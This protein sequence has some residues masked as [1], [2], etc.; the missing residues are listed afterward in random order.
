M[1]KSPSGSEQLIPIMLNEEKFDTIGNSDSLLNRN[2]DNL[3]ESIN[4]ETG[5]IEN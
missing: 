1:V 5:D 4:P 3:V 2:E